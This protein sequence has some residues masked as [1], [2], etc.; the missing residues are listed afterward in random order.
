MRKSHIT[1]LA[2]MLRRMDEREALLQKRVGDRVLASMRSRNMLDAEAI[3]AALAA[4]TST[5]SESQVTAPPVKV[6]VMSG[7]VRAPLGKR[8]AAR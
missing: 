7:T 1:R 8:P 5:G 4:L 3:R 2:T 6:T